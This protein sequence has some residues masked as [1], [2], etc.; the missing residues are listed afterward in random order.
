MTALHESCVT[1]VNAP[2]FDADWHR[3][4]FGVAVALSEFGHYPWSSF[5]QELIGAIGDWESSGRESWE[6]YEHWL[7]ALEHVLV[8]HGL[9]SAAE[10][11]TAPA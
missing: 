3:R 6:Y 1:D 4:A 9:V 5:Q 2:T 11:P 8:E 7:T 10:L